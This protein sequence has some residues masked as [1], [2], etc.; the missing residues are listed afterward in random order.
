M[1]TEHID[2]LLDKF[3]CGDTSREEEKILSNYFTQ[4][5]V[6]QK[7]EDD[8]K[9][10]TS[11]SD[12]E[13]VQLHAL[14]QRT[15][16]FIDLLQTTEVASSQPKRRTMWMKTLSIVASLFI[17]FSVGLLV[18]Q[19]TKKNR[20]ILAD[21]CKNPDEAYRATMDALELFAKKYS[22][23]I[24]PMEKANFHLQKTQKTINQTLK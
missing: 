22:K 12:F 10:F 14:A 18:H 3:Y 4:A 17:V 1:H 8:K 2:R 21:T 6:P 13:S 15:E 16:A 11:L 7:Y 24:E 9:V 23:G 5:D 19:Y 20:N